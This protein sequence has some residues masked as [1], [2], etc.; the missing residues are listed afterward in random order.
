MPSTLVDT[1]PLVALFD[2]RDKWHE[3]VKDFLARHQ[4]HQ[5]AIVTTWPVLTEVYFLV[6]QYIW[7]DF[8]GWVNDGAVTIADIP[9]DEIK[10]ILALSHKYKDLPMDFADASLIVLAEIQNQP[11]IITIDSDF[12]VYRFSVNRKF[13]NLLRGQL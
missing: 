12:D 1:G 3:I 13:N 5:L 11:D 2:R 10:R 7:L 9:A 4:R 6:E 8:L